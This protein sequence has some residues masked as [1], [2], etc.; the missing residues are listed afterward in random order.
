[1]FCL[2]KEIWLNDQSLAIVASLLCF[3][4]PGFQAQFTSWCYYYQKADLARKFGENEKITR[5]GGAA[6]NSSQFPNIASEW[7]PF[8]EDYF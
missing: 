8:L 5:L 4:Y 1:L 6:I 2:V 3:V 7:L